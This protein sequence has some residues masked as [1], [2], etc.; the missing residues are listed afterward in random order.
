MTFESCLIWQLS[1]REFGFHL[2]RVKL[3]LFYLKNWLAWVYLAI[4]LCEC[5]NNVGKLHLPGVVITKETLANFI[6]FSLGGR[7][8]QNFL[9]MF[10]RTWKISNLLVPQTS[11]S[12]WFPVCLLTVRGSLNITTRLTSSSWAGK[13]WSM[14]FGC[15][16]ISKATRY[17]KASYFILFYFFWC[18]T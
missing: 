16:V 4:Y 5:A 8:Y 2:N 15:N 7:S 6:F 17:Q 13:H 1:Q 10:M 12:N 18:D 9:F 11:H 3:D 14:N